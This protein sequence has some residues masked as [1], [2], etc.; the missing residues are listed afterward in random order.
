M[1]DKESLRGAI[2]IYRKQFQRQSDELRTTLLILNKLESD[3]GEAIT[4]AS[5]EINLGL[6]DRLAMSDAFSPSINGR[7]SEVRPDEF[8]G[9]SQS[10][11]ARAYL[12]KVSRAVSFDQLVQ[13]LRKGGAEVGGADPKKTL[14]VS[15]MRNPKG[16][17][18]IPSD[19]HV[20][21]RVFY[22]GLPKGGKTMKPKKTKKNKRT[23]K[24]GP[25]AE[26]GPS[27]IMQ[28]LTE[29]LRKEGPKTKSELVVGSE[30][31]LKRKI[32]Q[33]SVAGALRSKTFQQSDGKYELA[34]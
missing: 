14:Y 29:I 12:K 19:G 34:K 5:K 28:V 6:S 13:A 1:D 30:V 9:M 24:S 17:F 8:F 27:E 7:S 3:A 26:K 10:D 25:V 32:A 11:A 22:P 4:S 2:E 18:V 33:I 20:G 31:K 23:K 15:L 21:L 16:E